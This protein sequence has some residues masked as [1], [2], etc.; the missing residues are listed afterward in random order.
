M[1]L[2]HRAAVAIA[3]PALRRLGYDLVRRDARRF[4]A[5][6]YELYAYDSAEEY[7]AAQVEAN[8]RKLDRT[9][10]REANMVFLAGWL[11]E[12]VEP[13]RFGLCHGTRRGAEQRWLMEHLPGCR[14][15]G[16]EI[17]DTAEQF[18]DT[19]RWDFHEVKDEW[20]G[21]CDFVYSNSWDHARDPE[22][23]IRAWMS[24]LRPGGVCVL[25]HTPRHAEGADAADPFKASLPALVE[26]LLRWGDGA[27]APRW[28]LDAPDT[29]GMPY[30]TLVV[31]QRFG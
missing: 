26:R 27:W 5:A 17:S 8:R 12:H 2:L 13:L 21:A 14:V 22:R 7:V 24:C 6:G 30:V 31:V 3:R 10:A 16:T 18:P 9:W 19:I 29:A 1:A 20:L 28:L 15:L 4:A 11:R 23:C 25:E